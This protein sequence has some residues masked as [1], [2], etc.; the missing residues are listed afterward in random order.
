VLCTIAFRI[1]IDIADVTYMQ[2]RMEATK[3]TGPCT[4]HTLL[5]ETKNNCVDKDWRQ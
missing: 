5:L 3:I 1:V 4:L 2:N